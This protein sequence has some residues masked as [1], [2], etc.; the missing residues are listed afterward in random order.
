LLDDFE[1]LDT[2]GIKHLTSS[3]KDIKDIKGIKSDIDLREQEARI[4]KLR[5]DI[6]DNNKDDGKVYGV[7][8]MPPI[9]DA[10]TPPSEEGDDG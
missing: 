4:D 9:M 1:M 7:L 8:M 3:L 6:D 10:L 2:Q 5:K